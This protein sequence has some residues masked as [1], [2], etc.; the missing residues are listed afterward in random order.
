MGLLTLEV[1]SGRSYSVRGNSGHPK[2]PD[3]DTI[4]KVERRRAI[5][6]LFI[7]IAILIMSGSVYGDDINL[8][9]PNLYDY[10][11]GPRVNEQRGLASEEDA[12][13]A[14]QRA[15]MLLEQ[16]EEKVSRTQLD[17]NLSDFTRAD[18]PEEGSLDLASESGEAPDQRAEVKARVEMIL[19]GSSADGDNSPA[20]Q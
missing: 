15:L 3:C 7:L 14:A 19:Q 2:V 1:K 12:H 8:D 6:N 10:N 17:V 4:K 13:E 18:S 16:G 20:S 11:V 9:D 5:K